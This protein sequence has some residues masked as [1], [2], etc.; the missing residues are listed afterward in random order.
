MICYLIL[1]HLLCRN[2]LYASTDGLNA[3][4]STSLVSNMILSTSYAMYLTSCLENFEYEKEAYY[5]DYGG[6]VLFS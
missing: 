3:V 1:L 5:H 6:R 2:I 4:S